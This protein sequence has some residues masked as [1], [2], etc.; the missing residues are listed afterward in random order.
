M[1]RRQRIEKALAGETVDRVP[2]F[3]W[4]FWQGDDQRA[5]DL[6]KAVLQ[7]QQAYDWDAV[8]VPPAPH[9]LVTGY[10][11]QDDWRGDIT[12]KRTVLKYPIQRSLDWT[13]LR[14]LDILRGDTHKFLETLRLLN[15]SPMLVGCPL[16]PVVFSP[17]AQA[18]QL[19]P[20]EHFLRHLRTQPD[21]LRTGLNV[22]TESTLRLLEA[23]K[24]LAIDG[25]YYVMEG[26]TLSLLSEAEYET[27][28]LPYDEKVLQATPNK[29]W[30]NIA[31]LV[32]ESP[33]LKATAQLP[34][35]AVG[36]EVSAHNPALHDGKLITQKATIGG[37][38]R[39]T[40]HDG[41]PLSIKDAARSAV[42][43][44]NGRKLM[45]SSD[46]AS[47][48]TTPLSNLQALRDSVRVAVL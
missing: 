35:S 42:N 47:L 44:T 34:I 18:L 28:G 10:G 16:L 1:E 13:E 22:L 24:R 30:L 23:F 41:T 31:H 3:L 33:M 11:L 25:I 19:V 15:A 8:V 21:R 14:P 20:R 17:L 2:V 39:L 6:A 32:G 45:L 4:R 26:A 43:A 48:V 27:F 46:G 36:W 29:W 12:G 38:S 5:A 7:F 37:V 40:L 9:A